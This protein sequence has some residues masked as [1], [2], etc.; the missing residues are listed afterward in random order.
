MLA[1]PGGGVLLTFFLSHPT[2]LACSRGRLTCPPADLVGKTVFGTTAMSSGAAAAL[3]AAVGLVAL[4]VAA[5]L[6]D[7]GRKRL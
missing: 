7:F 5:L 3:S 4:F 6:T 2:H 1:A